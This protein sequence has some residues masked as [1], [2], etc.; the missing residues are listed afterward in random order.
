MIYRLKYL[1]CYRVEWGNSEDGGNIN[2]I[3]YYEML[4]VELCDVNMNWVVVL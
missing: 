4:Y 2:N 3:K 1:L